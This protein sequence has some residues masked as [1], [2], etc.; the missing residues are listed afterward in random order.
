MVKFKKPSE[1]PKKENKNTQKGFTPKHNEHLPNET[2]FRKH[3][4][5]KVESHHNLR[6][7]RGK[8]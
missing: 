5:V 7:P 8:G 1:N 4:F 2:S 3:E 6:T